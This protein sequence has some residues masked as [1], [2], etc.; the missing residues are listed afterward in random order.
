MLSVMIR[1]DWGSLWGMIFAHKQTIIRNRVGIKISA[2][3]PLRS[4]LR[5][6]VRS[7]A[8]MRCSDTSRDIFSSQFYHETTEIHSRMICE[9]VEHRRNVIWVI[10]QNRRRLSRTFKEQNHSLPSMRFFWP[11]KIASIFLC[12]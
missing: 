12:R 8:F 5:P 9:A 7:S 1:I 11:K 3:F 4:Y 6:S 2:I 10:D